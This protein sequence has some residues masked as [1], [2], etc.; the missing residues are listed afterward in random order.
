MSK[1]TNTYLDRNGEKWSIEKGDWKSHQQ[2]DKKQYDKQNAKVKTFTRITLSI[3]F[4]ALAIILLLRS[5]N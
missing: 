3:I 5:L 1:K 4:I 2:T